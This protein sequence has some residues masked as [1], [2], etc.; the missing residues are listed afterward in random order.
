MQASGQL[1]APA[2][3]PPGKEPWYPLNRRLG[4]PQSR[5]GCFS[6]V[7]GYSVPHR[8]MIIN[9]EPGIIWKEVLMVF[10]KVLF[11]NSF[12]GTRN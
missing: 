6:T 7:L 11:N 1:H 3:L 12:G 4:G 2:A 9:N 10:V 8:N 5:S